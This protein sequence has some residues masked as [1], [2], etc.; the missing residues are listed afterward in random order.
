MAT[1]TIKINEKTKEG[2]SLLSFLKSLKEVVSISE[3][4]LSPAIDEAMEDLNTGNTFTTKNSV[5]LLN[6]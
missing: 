6:Q 5:D 3:L 1:C 4:K 2:K